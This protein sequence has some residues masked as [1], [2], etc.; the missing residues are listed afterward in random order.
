MAVLYW[1]AVRDHLTLGNSPWLPAEWLVN[2]S[3]F[4]QYL[5]ALLWALMTTIGASPSEHTRDI[6][7]TW[8]YL[9]G[10]AAGLIMQVVVI[11]AVGDALRAMS[12]RQDEKRHREEEIHGST[13][14]SYTCLCTCL[15]Q[16]LYACLYTC[17]CQ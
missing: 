3:D 4:D 2:E 15:C 14:C 6:M 12:Q 11:A 8:I 9:V 10:L 7:E 5:H 17:L 1:W 16:Y 13:T